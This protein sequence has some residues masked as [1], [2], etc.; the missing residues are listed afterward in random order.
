MTNYQ[1][2]QLCNLSNK[3][4]QIIHFFDSVKY[5]FHKKLQTSKYTILN[6]MIAQYHSAYI[7]K[8]K[9]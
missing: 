5:E 3:Y 1:H 6:N 8:T 7:L 4:E 2:M 9:N